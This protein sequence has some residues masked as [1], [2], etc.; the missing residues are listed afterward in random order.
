MCELED[1]ACWSIATEPNN[2]FVCP[3]NAAVDSQGRL[4]IATDQGK[5][6]YEKS[7]RADGLYALETHGPERG[8][9]RL[10]YRVPVGA[11]ATGPCFTPN[12]ET[13]FLSVQHPGTDGVRDYEDKRSSANCHDS[14][15]GPIGSTTGEPFDNSKPVSFENPASRWPDFKDG[16][17]PRPSVVVITRKDGGKIGG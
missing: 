13:L 2:K 7:K 10:F 3:D 9:P 16:M 1:E 6:W 17:P 15:E 8:T 4:W 12:G 5:H 14:S 11:E